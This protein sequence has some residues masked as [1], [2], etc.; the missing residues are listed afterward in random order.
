MI[1][2]GEKVDGEDVLHI[3]IGPESRQQFNFNGQTTMDI[4]DYI[5]KMSNRGGKCKLVLNE[6]DSEQN[7]LDIIAY[8]EGQKKIQSALKGINLGGMF[9]TPDEGT[10][11][12]NKDPERRPTLKKSK[13]KSGHGISCPL[14]LR[15]NSAI[16]ISGIVHPC[17]TCQRIEDG[18]S[19][20]EVSDVPTKEEL[21]RLRDEIEGNSP[22]QKKSLSKYIEDDEAETD[23]ELHDPDDIM[24]DEEMDDGD[25][26][27]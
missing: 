27:E 13:D 15:K 18:L 21:D 9:D 6:C 24:D 14:C 8:Q 4:T 1:V 16:I 11:T 25:Q 2:F 5:Q 19:A 12:K 10:V 26:P 17:E 23:I 7:I 22:E 3:I 20:Q